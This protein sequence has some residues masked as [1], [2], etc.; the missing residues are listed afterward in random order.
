MLER[1]QLE[2]LAV[3]GWWA[4][5][6]RKFTCLAGIQFPFKDSSHEPNGVRGNGAGTQMVD[7]A[8]M[9]AQFV[10]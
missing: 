6:A 8:N 2:G 1:R 10:D 3:D 4:G 9:G 7:R 5:N